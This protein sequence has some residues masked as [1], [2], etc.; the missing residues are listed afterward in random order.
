MDMQVSY[1][2]ISAVTTLKAVVANTS[3]VVPAGYAID[4]ICLVNT[5]ANAVTGGVKLGTTSGATDVIIALAVGANAV[6]AVLDATILKRLFSQT[7]D[8]TLFLQTV[9][10]WNSAS[11][12][13]SISMHKVF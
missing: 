5:T 2:P 4:M 9:T 8:Q 3:F 10:L 1:P 12:D 11:V 7:V 6:L 13:F